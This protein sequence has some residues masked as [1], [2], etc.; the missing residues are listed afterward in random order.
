MIFNEQQVHIYRKYSP[1]KQLTFL[2]WGI[3]FLSSCVPY[4]RIIETTDPL[5]GI[6]KMKLAFASNALSGEKNGILSNSQPSTLETT[7]LYEER[8]NDQPAISVNFQITTP[9]RSEEIDSVMFLILDDEKIR[10]VSTKHQEFNNNYKSQTRLKSRTLQKI[11]RLFFM[12][13]NLWIAIAN[14][15]K[16]QYRIYLGNKGFD[17]KLNS[18]EIKKLKYFFELAMCKRDAASPPLP[19]GLKRL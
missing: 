12:P 1:M 15:E 3:L 6:N 10:I 4:S 17:A 14:S 7:Y 18:S 8:K 13:D 2:L 19:E 11:N 16:I 9:I 5:K